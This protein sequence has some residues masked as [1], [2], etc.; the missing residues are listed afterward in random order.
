[1]PSDTPT[2]H[3]RRGPSVARNLTISLI[4]TVT[5]IILAGTTAFTSY[6]IRREKNELIQ[7]SGEIADLAAQSLRL[8]LWFLHI[9]SITQIG[10]AYSTNRFV[11][12]LAINDAKGKELYQYTAQEDSEQEE[13][14]LHRDISY[15]GEVLGTLTMTVTTHGLQEKTLGLLLF[16][17]MVIVLV[18]LAL[19]VLTGVSLRLFLRRPLQQLEEQVANYSAGDQASPAAQPP[20][21]EFVSLVSTLHEMA[22]RIQSQVAEL[23]LAESRYRS[24]FE[25]ALEGMFRSSVEGKL[26][27]VNPAMANMLGY[28]SPQDM[29][30]KVGNIE[31]TLYDDAA[32]RA[33]F[34]D[35]L[36]RD[37]AVE[38]FETV[39]RRKDGSQRWVQLGALLLEEKGE[40]QG[41]CQDVT[42]QIQVRNALV[43]AK[44]AAEEASQLKSDF[45]SMVSHELRTPLTSV[46]G[47]SK[48]IRKRLNQNVLPVL[49]ETGGK[50]ATSLENSLDQF[51]IIIKEG[52]RLTRLINNVLDLAKLEAGRLELRVSPCD[53]SQLM[54]K[55]LDALR[56]LFEEKGLDM[57]LEAE[58]ELPQIQCDPDRIL[59][60]LINLISNAIR[61][62]AH[63]EIACRAR[64]QDR[65]IMVTVDDQGPGI[66]SSQASSVFD[67][68]KQLGDT[69]REPNA[70]TGL[71][72]AICRE[73]VHLHGGTIWFKNKPDGG[74][75]AFSFT[76]PA[77]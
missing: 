77:R 24:L 56:S 10:R 72:L 38:E 5:I 75:C 42:R 26:L 28:D 73:I 64:L 35:I 33:R 67:M 55:A 36:R 45:L 74:G 13:I 51:D 20:P 47:F 52:D 71:G 70:G 23:A 19:A 76:L 16:G 43:A 57:V 61:F 32:E 44:E 59:Q 69:V 7:Y 21:R 54:Q 68:F 12:G 34:F 11:V 14:L 46:V 48:L 9:D 65:Q 17:G 31:T 37:G 60:V 50:P 62:T 25:N 40:I 29:L 63:G 22:E 41:N 53:I 49:T 2:K 27:M 8:P 39:F 58:S 30:E 6:Q 3:F 18:S 4:S 1:M 15:Q 66:H